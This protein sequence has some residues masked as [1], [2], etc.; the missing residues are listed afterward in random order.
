MSNS[1]ATTPLSALLHH[2]PFVRYWL[3]RMGGVTANQMLM[4]AVAWHMYDITS[5][6]WD[7][8]LVG[9]FQF[10]PALLMALPAGHV[11][12]R[13]H[14]GR[15]F[16]CS[17][18][19][20]ATVAAVML[21]STHYGTA[22]REL[23]LLLSVV[24][25]IARA[26]QMPA[27]Q[28]IL[29]S[30]VPQTLLPRAIALNASGMEIAVISGPALGGLIYT[31]GAQWVYT[32]CIVLLSIAI[33]LIL[34]VDYSHKPPPAAQGWQGFFAGVAFVWRRKVVLGATTLDL[35]AV[36]LGGA[37]ALLPIY[38]KDILHTGPIG[39][40]VLRSSPAIGAFCMSLAL[41]RWPLHRK[42]GAKLLSAV[43]IFGLAIVIF[44]LST[45]FFVS[46]LALIVTGA[47]DCVSVVVR[48]SLVQLE[49]PDD[50]RGRV[51][52]VNSIFIGASNQLGEFESGATAAMWGPV[53]SVVAGGVGTMLIAATW[54]KL[55]PALAQRDH[56]EPHKE[57]AKT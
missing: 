47:A 35:F 29:P 32:T 19:A 39:L 48:G 36:L 44:G 15:I 10:V 6:P 56:M 40:G 33:T 22:T 26:F 38:A 18:A 21:L 7:L 50:M 11:A 8:G 25:G 31:L 5:S 52:A 53:T 46:M 20:Q 1:T 16:A 9:L 37:T 17:L 42:V 43:A 45:S 27:Q 12:D 24:L 3:G 2:A 30:L 49:T 14:R 41:A 4:V 28:A 57:A 23:I 55:F 13:V 54:L 51:A 34:A